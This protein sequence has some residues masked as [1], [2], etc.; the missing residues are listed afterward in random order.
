MRFCHGQ[1]PF[2]ALSF[3]TPIYGADEARRGLEEGSKD[4]PCAIIVARQAAE[5][6][7]VV[8]VL[9]ITHSPPSEAT[10]AI[11]LPPQLK[12]HLGLDDQPSW[13]L[14]SEMNDFVWPGPDLRAVPATNPPEFSYG[15]IPPGFFAKIRNAFVEYVRD[16]RML[17]VTRSE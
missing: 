13:V 5:D 1:N 15:V 6:T 9:P 4:R 12:T 14:L 2:P 17:R 8:S 7:Q 16:R 10:P 3:P 11:E